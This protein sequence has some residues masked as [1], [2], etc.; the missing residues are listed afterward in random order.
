ATGATGET[1]ATGA[2]G[3]TGATGA[4]GDTGATG[5]TGE[6][7]ATGATGETGA[8]GAT[9]ETGA[10]GATGETGATGATGETG[11]AFTDVNAF[12]A[13]TSGAIIAVLLGGTDI[14]LP[15]DHILNGITINGASTIITIPTAG[16]YMISYQI[17][18]TAALAVNSQ[19][20]ING[21]AL[22]PSIV[23]PVLSLSSFNNTVITVLGAG[24]TVQLQLFGLL[25]A[26]TLLGGGAGAA[27]TI[28]Q[29]S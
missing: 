14:P 23:N 24:T 18:L 29:V 26:A 8:T 12:A 6:T 16:T 1:G 27:L 11:E 4:T 25:G 28:V 5:A 13:N 17:N 19:L 10:T 3:E 22:T 9:G 2:T 15:D 21:V 7:G 20:L